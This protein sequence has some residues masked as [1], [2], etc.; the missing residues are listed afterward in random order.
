MEQ[1]YNFSTTGDQEGSEYNYWVEVKACILSN[2]RKRIDNTKINMTAF[3]IYPE[4]KN[5]KIKMISS[6]D[7]FYFSTHANISMDR[8][9]KAWKLAFNQCPGKTSR[10]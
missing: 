9:Q 10:F 4:F 2:G 1:V 6:D 7:K 8:L 3:R 5:K